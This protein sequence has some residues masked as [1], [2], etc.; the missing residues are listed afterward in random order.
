LHGVQGVVCSNHTV[1]TNKIKDLGQ[2]LS[3]PFL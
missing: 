2:L 3:W 1:P